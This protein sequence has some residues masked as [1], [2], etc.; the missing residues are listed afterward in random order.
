MVEFRYVRISESLVTELRDLVSCGASL[1]LLG[2]RNIGKRYLI[3]RLVDPPAPTAGHVGLVSFLSGVPDDDE[4]Q[5]KAAGGTVPRLTRLES[6]PPAVLGW[7]DERLGAGEG[8]VTLCAANVDALTHTEIQGFLSGLKERV[9]RHGRGEGRLAVVLTGEVDLGRFVSDSQYEFT[10]GKQFIIQ[11]FARDEFRAFADHYVSMLDP[12][13]EPLNDRM[14]GHLYDRTGGNTYLL[15]LILWSIFDHEASTISAPF[16]PVSMT[17]LPTEIVLTQPPWTYYLRAMTRQ[18]D[19]DPSCWL[20]LERLVD[21]GRILIGDGPPHVL[22]LAGVAVRENGRFTIP[23]TLVRDYLRQRYTPR[24]FGDLYV[25]EG[26]WSEAFHRYDQVD[27][28]ERYRPS[29]IE[30]VP[31]AE[32]AVKH[33]S[34]SLYREVTRGPDAILRRFRDGCRY[35][36]GFPEVT[37][38]RLTDAGWAPIRETLRGLRNVPTFDQP[39]LSCIGEYRALLDGISLKGSHGLV[40]VDPAQESCLRV[41]RISTSHPDLHEVIIVG[42]PGERNILSRAREQMTA[43]LIHDFLDAHGHAWDDKL[44]DDRAKFQKEFTEIASEVVERLGTEIREVEGALKLAAVLLRTKLRYKRVCISVI[45]PKGVMTVPVVQEADP[46]LPRVKDLELYRYHLD[47]AR[48]SATIWTIKHA[49]PLV[50]YDATTDPKANNA[51]AKELGITATALIPL[52]DPQ[53]LV[54]GI[55][56]VE[57]A[58]GRVPIPP[59]VSAL[60]DFGKKLAVALQLNEQISMLQGALDTLPQPIAIF[61]RADRARYLNKLAYHFLFRER[62]AKW[63]PAGTGPRYDNLARSDGDREW[64]ARFVSLVGQ[65]LADSKP[66]SDRTDVTIRGQPFQLD[67]MVKPI[68]DWRKRLAAAQQADTD[69][70]AGALFHTQDVTYLSRAFEALEELI[71]ASGTNEVIERTIEAMR[72]LEHRWCRLYVVNPLNESELESSSCFGPKPDVEEWEDKFNSGGYVIPRYDDDYRW[73]GWQCLKENRPLALFYDPNRADKDRV[74]N[75]YGLEAVNCKDQKCAP[76]L[77]KKPGEYWIDFPLFTPDRLFGK[78]TLEWKATRRPEDVRT[79]SVFCELTSLLLAEAVR[80]ED[81]EQET[82]RIHRQAAQEA[83]SEVL[84]RIKTP[85]ATLLKVS[86]RQG[87]L[88]GKLRQELARGDSSPECSRLLKDLEDIVATSETICGEIVAYIAEEK[89]KKELQV[90]PEIKRIDL[91]ALL[92]RMLPIEGDQYRVQLDTDLVNY[93]MDLDGILF[94]YMLREMFINAGKFPRE[95]IPVQVTVSVD[96]FQRDQNDWVRVYI[97]DNGTGV[98][99]ANKQKIFEKGFRASSNGSDGWGL[100]LFRARDLIVKHRGEIR[101]VGEKRVGAVFEIELPRF[102]KA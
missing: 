92:R 73:E 34:T 70:M 4:V 25:R 53:N 8:R 77:R 81:Q 14:L 35:I 59:E 49:Q 18:I 58:D 9:E 16:H 62:E 88:I 15:R 65:T 100:G 30:D 96:T 51:V 60:F 48:P 7:V 2:P 99:P 46:G 52:V 24:R 44:A 66:H 32:E 102:Q 23:E 85:P 97:A 90:F 41:V 28:S 47:D 67:A 10:C 101:E 5:T 3:H 17:S 56:Q 82:A 42:R 6:K 19:G 54:M 20:D 84:H 22:E 1:V 86:H 50:M 29:T 75:K 40:P 38:W 68:W 71:T 80:R 27:L 43:R 45:D 36:M 12:K 91:A 39:D 89:E 55:V 69:L 76:E 74:K 33:L 64:L 11:G 83:L 37:R 95:N 98:S 31:D 61:D 13:L 21:G 87:E 57:R 78:L 63:Y 93:M 72:R 26:S 94:E 79:L